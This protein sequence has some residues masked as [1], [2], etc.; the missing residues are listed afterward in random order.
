MTQVLELATDGVTWPEVGLAAVVVLG[1]LGLL[2]V[3]CR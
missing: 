2:W 3:L 1:I